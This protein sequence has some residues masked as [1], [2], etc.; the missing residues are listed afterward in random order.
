VGWD[1]FVSA[2]VYITAEMPRSGNEVMSRERSGLRIS[3][4][5]VI[6]KFRDFIMD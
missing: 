3:D 6:V 2:G 1:F 5:I 4:L